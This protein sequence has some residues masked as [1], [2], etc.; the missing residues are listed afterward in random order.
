MSILIG[1]SL[2]QSSQDGAVKSPQH[3]LLPTRR[4]KK[5]PIFGGKQK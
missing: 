4:L 3:K 1:L 2:S 5:V